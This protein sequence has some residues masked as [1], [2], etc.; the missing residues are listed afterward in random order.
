[1]CIGFVPE[2][3]ETDPRKAA[4][5][6]ALGRSAAVFVGTVTAMEYVPVRTELFGGN[7]AQ[8]LVIK[9]S[10][11]AWWKGAQSQQV[12]LHTHTYLLPGGGNSLEAHEFQYEKGKT[13]LVFA[14]TYGGALYANICTRTKLIDAAAEDIVSLDALKAG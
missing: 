11:S 4:V 2:P 10:P 6:H 14:N 8:M 3:G 7:E 12:T 9:L 1:M 5:R 13:Y